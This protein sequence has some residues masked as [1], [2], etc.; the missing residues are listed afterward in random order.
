MPSIRIRNPQQ[1]RKTNWTWYRLMI[2]RIWIWRAKVKNKGA[3]LKKHEDKRQLIFPFTFEFRMV[4]DKTDDPMEWQKARPWKEVWNDTKRK[5]KNSSKRI[6]TS[7]WQTLTDLRSDLQIL[8]ETHIPSENPSEISRAKFLQLRRSSENLGVSKKASI[9]HI[10]CTPILALRGGALTLPSYKH[11][12]N[13]TQLSREVSCETPPSAN[14]SNKKPK[15]F[16]KLIVRIGKLKQRLKEQLDQLP[17]KL[18][19]KLRNMDP[20]PDNIQRTLNKI[21]RLRSKMHI[22]KRSEH[23]N[24]PHH[25]NE[26]LR[27]LSGPSPI[28]EERER[29]TLPSRE[30]N[31]GQTGP[32][33]NPPASHSK[34][35]KTQAINKCTSRPNTQK[36]ASQKVKK[37]IRQRSEK[38]TGWTGHATCN[39][40]CGPRSG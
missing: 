26:R 24:T 37:T 27:H 7:K 10:C 21:K 40:P 22:Y 33:S 34:P 1:S 5:L 38:V 11:T 31:G 18:K 3:D 15:Q 30:T 8:S 36:S 25:T 29:R 16:N 13:K 6:K 39:L 12:S 32:A 4:D 20:E 19:F 2:I 17:N 9:L 23:A 14:T 28:L 35:K